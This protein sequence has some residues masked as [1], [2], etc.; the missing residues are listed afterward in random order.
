MKIKIISVLTAVL[1]AFV[2]YAK[3]TIFDDAVFWFRGGKECVT[4]NGIMETGEFFDA[5][6]ANDVNHANHKLP[7]VGYSENAE[8][9][10]E[11]VVFP[12]LGTGV[13]QELQILHLANKTQNVDGTEVANPVKIKAKDL[14]VNNKISSQYSVVARLKLDELSGTDKLFAIGY[15]GGNQRGVLL[16]FENFSW[17]KP[18]CKCVSLYRTKDSGSLNEYVRLESVYVLTNTWFDLSVSVGSG[19]IRIGIATADKYSNTRHQVVFEETPLWTDNCTLL[20]S[21]T[22]YCFFAEKYSATKGN[23]R[24]SVQ[25][26]ALWNRTF[27]DQEVMEAFG[28]PRPA[29][30]QIGLANGESDEFGGTR[31]GATQ[32][33]EGLGAWHNATDSMMAGDTWTVN[34]PVLTSESD[35]RGPLVPYIFSLLSLP[36]SETATLSVSLNGTSLGRRHIGKT[37]KAYWPVAAGLFVPGQNTLTIKRTDKRSGAFKVD[38]MELGGALSVGYLNGNGSEMGSAIAGKST[39]ATSPNPKYWWSTLQAYENKNDMVFKVWVDPDLKD[40]CPA[41]LELRSKCL[42]RSDAAGQVIKGGEYFTIYVNGKEKGTRDH[43]NPN[44]SFEKTLI[45]FE[46]GELKAGWNE[47]NLRSAIYDCYWQIDYYRFWLTLDEGFT[48]PPAPGPGFV[49]TAR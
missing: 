23:F 18:N 33:I 29:I 46:P 32:S 37:S 24:G 7:V 19:K 39:S 28:M 27:T 36:D 11:N 31:T 17:S 25:Q 1:T 21:D 15:D 26:L 14:F 10:T 42:N 12:S 44:N 30:F 38:A 8:F 48:D 20:Y 22:P 43:I 5:L 3:S 34:F 16:S 2:T 4:A 40:R 35:S 45:N 13:A 47:V 49:I 9:R 6:H 41:T